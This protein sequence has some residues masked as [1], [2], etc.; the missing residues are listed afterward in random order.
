MESIPPASPPSL[1][2]CA[3]IGQ[4]N[5][6][7]IIIQSVYFTCKLCPIIMNEGG[8]FVGK[9]DRTR[10]RG[11]PLEWRATS[12]QSEWAVVSGRGKRTTASEAVYK[13]EDS[14]V[15][16]VFWLLLYKNLQIFTNTLELQE[17]VRLS[18][19]HYYA[20]ISLVH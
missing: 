13:C 16:S 7:E 17:Q 11:F 10:N 5:F 14:T 1:V 3:P 19:L 9:P 15:A 20:F 2:F 6:D 18:E 8:I 12:I 4:Y